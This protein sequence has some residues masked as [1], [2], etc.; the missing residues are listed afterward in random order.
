MTRAL[1]LFLAAVIAATSLA[2]CNSTPNP[3]TVAEARPE[4]AV[5]YEL[6]FQAWAWLDGHN[7]A[8]Y[9]AHARLVTKAILE[10]RKEFADTCGEVFAEQCMIAAYN[11]I[12]AEWEKES[13]YDKRTERLEV[14]RKGLRAMSSVLGSDPDGG[15]FDWAP[16]VLTV[17]SALN[18]LAKEL[19]ASGVDLPDVVEAGL[20]AIGGLS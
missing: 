18:A 7:A 17:A 6:T 4:L 15:A 19:E 5:A 16:A 8:G 10:K 2:G 9:E 11:A 1:A 14:A 20:E 13:G 3:K 12:M